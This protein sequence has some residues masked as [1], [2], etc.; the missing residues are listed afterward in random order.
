[1]AAPHVSGAAALIKSQTPG[2]S[3]SQIRSLLEVNADDLGASGRDDFFGHGRINLLQAFD[4]MAPV[5]TISTVSLTNGEIS[6]SYGPETLL[7]SGGY[8]PVIW[9]VMPMKLSTLA[10]TELVEGEFREWRADEQ[11]WKIEL[12][13]AFPYNGKT[14]THAWVSANGFLDFGDTAP[15]PEAYNRSYTLGWRIRIAPLWDDLSTGGIVNRPE[16]IYTGQP[17]ADSF[18]VRWQ[19]HVRGTEQPVNFACVLFLD[20]R[21]RF[22]YGN[23]NQQLSPTVGLG[24]GSNS[25]IAVWGYNDSNNLQNAGS[26]LFTPGGLPSGM[27]LSG[28]GTLSGIPVQGGLFSLRIEAEDSIG[29]TIEKTFSLFIDDPNTQPPRILS[30]SPR[31]GGQVIT[32]DTK[33]PSFTEVQVVFNEDINIDVSDANV[34]NSS[35][36]PQ[37]FTVNYIPSSLT[38]MINFDPPLPID[39]YTFTI[40]DSVTD[41]D[42]MA[43]DGEIVDDQLPSGDLVAGGDAV[44]TLEVAPWWQEFQVNTYTASYQQYPSVAMDAEGNFVI[45]WSSMSQD[46]DNSSGVYAQRY[47]ADGIPIGSEFQ[48]NT[49][50]VDGQS[51]PSV[52]MDSAGNFVI[53][54]TSDGQDGDRDGIYAQR[55]DPDGIAQGGEF[56][57][58]THTTDNHINPSMAMNDAGDFVI[59]WESWEQDDDLCGVYSQYFRKPPSVD[60]ATPAPSSV[61]PSSSTSTVTI[62]FND[63]VVIS[64]SDVSVLDSFGTTHNDFS[65][66]YDV[67]TFKSLLTWAVPL[68]SG[69]A[70]EITVADSVY[71]PDKRL[72]F[73]PSKDFVVGLDGEWA[74]VRGPSGDGTEGGDAVW[75]FCVSRDSPWDGDNRVN[76]TINGVQSDAAAAGLRDNLF[77]A[78][79]TSTTGDSD[80]T[81]VVGGRF[82]QFGNYIGGEFLVNVTETGNQAEPAM[83]AFRDGQ[84]VVVWSGQGSGDADGIFIR[85]FSPEGF[86]V[87]DEVLV[88][89]YTTNSQDKPAVAISEDGQIVV[90]WQSSGQD[91]SGYGIYGQCLAEDLSFSGNEFQP[92]TTTTDDQL[93]P[94]VTWL[95]SGGFLVVWESP[96]GLGSGIYGQEYGAE[97]LKIGGEFDVSSLVTG[98]QI[99]PCSAPLPDGGF[100]AVWQDELF[101][102]NSWGIVGRVVDPNRDGGSEFVISEVTSGDQTNPVVDRLSSG[103]LIVTWQSTA[104]TPPGDPADTGVYHRRIDG[105]NAAP[106]GPEVLMNSYTPGFQQ[107]PAIGSLSDGDFVVVWDGAGPFSDTEGVYGRWY[108]AT[109]PMVTSSY[110]ESAGGEVTTLVLEFNE[111]VSVSL[112]SVNVVGQSTG[113]QTFSGDYD[114]HAWVLK[115][116]FTDP[117]EADNYLVNIPTAAVTGITGSSLDGNG[118]GLMGDDLMLDFIVNIPGDFEPDGDVDLV[119]FSAFAAHWQ[120]SPCNEGNNWCNKADMD[121]LDGV[122]IKDLATFAEN[123]LANTELPLIP[124]GTAEIDGYLNDWAGAVWIPTDK[125]YS[126][127][128]P[129]DVSDAYWSAKWDPVGNRIYVAVT[130]VDTDHVFTPDRQ[131]WDDADLVEIFIDAG[132]RNGA[133][134]SYQDYAQQYCVANDGSDDQWIVMGLNSTIPDPDMPSYAAKVNGNVLTYEICL[135]PWNYYTGLG[136][137]DEAQSTVTLTEGH[138]IGLDVVIDSRWIGSGGGF[139]MLCNNTD[140]G[141]YLDAGQ[142]Q[143]HT[144]AGSPP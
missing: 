45:A 100:L 117:L 126:D 90:V 129:P 102:S 11:V 71:R 62:E 109:P 73:S 101:D 72:G 24:F 66:S 15:Y 23:G 50:S 98:N 76:F 115:L 93:N 95:A 136:G 69:R 17:D 21:I 92:H 139:G 3:M 127:V 83:A 105:V 116:I 144:L 118:D 78:A 18:M 104:Q 123:W 119:D 40:S 74:D 86:Q 121:H 39:T 12:P 113:S 91:A 4:A 53:V 84:F 88:N 68:P 20:G 49:Y 41:S 65:F 120:E 13:F 89:T 134:E 114:V 28:D 55:Y 133:L 122:D 110:T 47:D 138:T 7:S 1:M 141:K 54:W 106:L 58:N 51:I 26:L 25:R 131:E 112:G 6:A 10:T 16:D 99:K 9:N 143:N 135:T 111:R 30:A 130:L 29:Q 142:F 32:V 34:V 94:H 125:L 77:A 2:L 44:W 80:G 140:N 87:T 19:G 79:W 107:R 56:R 42:V 137:S 33:Q 97:G 37:P 38:A 46:P 60:S 57:V 27:S 124:Q 61:I 43:L 75:T 108:D 103:D 31:P 52:A 82:D 64:S 36:D 14:Y 8:P 96:D 70:Y 67:N 59:A 128:I 132:N 48:V 22:D 35:S 81:G 63:D 5:L 85:K